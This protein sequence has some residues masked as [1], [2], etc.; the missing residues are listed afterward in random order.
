MSGPFA[1][2]L[3][4]VS[5]I[6]L[7]YRPASYFWPLPLATH[8]LARIKGA[9]RKALAR[10]L[11]A[12]GRLAELPPELAQSSLS[13]ADRAVQGSLHPAFLGGEFLPDL[14]E[15]EVEIARITIASVTQDVTSVYARRG[16]RRIYYRVVDDYG[17]ETLTGCSRRTSRHPLSLGQLERFF[18]GA[19][20]LFTVLEAN[21][22]DA[23]YDPG[24]MLSFVT[25][26][27]SEFYPEIGR[28]YRQRITD[29][30]ALRRTELELDTFER[31][32]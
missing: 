30:A 23:G 21:F 1:D 31:T 13:A 22:S 4:P 6:D 9:E 11:A 20:S 14:G 17:G 12:S 24:Q 5:E 32:P 2:G 10:R 8:R 29:W 19:W 3:P 15:R 27:E 7:N 26:V 28:L 25:R 18:H 16:K